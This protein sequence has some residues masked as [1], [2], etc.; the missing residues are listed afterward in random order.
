MTQV[1]DAPISFD[2]DHQSIQYL[3][4]AY[5]VT[6]WERCNVISN[7]IGRFF[8]S[9]FKH[10]D[11]AQSNI[12]TILNECLENAYKF[13]VESNSFISLRFFYNSETCRIETVN[14]SSAKDALKLKE[15]LVLLRSNNV[16]QIYLDQLKKVSHDNSLSSGLGLLGLAKDFEAKIDVDIKEKPG[17][18][19]TYQVFLMV[20]IPSHKLDSND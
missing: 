17:S 1:F 3:I 20:N 13:S 9:H 18:D 11:Y 14:D 10:P 16:E 8:A 7:Y 5:L 6:E 15:L 12:S 4:P 19:T 2:G